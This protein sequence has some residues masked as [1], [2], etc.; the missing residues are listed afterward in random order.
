M[1]YSWKKGMSIDDQWQ[2][3]QD[4]N[5]LDKIPDVDTDDLKQALIKDLS[6]VSS[7]DVKEYTL[8]QKW[9]E[10]KDRYPTI[11]T[12]SL[13]AANPSTFALNADI[14]SV[15]RTT[16]EPSPYLGSC[17]FASKSEANNS[18]LCPKS[19]KVSI[20]TPKKV[21][22]FSEYLY[23]ANSWWFWIKLWFL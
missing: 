19:L 5:P 8:Y 3:W 18:L 9:C 10:V 21:I 13:F 7:M 1:T 17:I 4:N 23:L 2:S 16:I 20:I 12:N 15:F 22:L 6:Y 11:E 14:L